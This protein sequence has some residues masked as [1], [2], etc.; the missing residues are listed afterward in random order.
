MTHTTFRGKI[1]LFFVEVLQ[2]TIE[3]RLKRVGDLK[4][5]LTTQ[6]YAYHMSK[7]QFMGQNLRDLGCNRQ[8]IP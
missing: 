3:Y 7:D 6:G 2:K 1:I 5:G 4:S 8:K